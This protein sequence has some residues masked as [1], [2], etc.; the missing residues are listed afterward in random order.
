VTFNPP[1]ILNPN[2]TAH[3]LAER[4]PWKNTAGEACP[5]YGVFRI[6]S[7]NETTLHWDAKKPDGEEGLYYVNGPVPVADTKYGGAAM[8]NLPRRV[9]VDS[10]TLA[11]GDEVGPVDGEWAMSASGVGWRIMRP[12]ETGGVVATVERIGGGSS[13]VDG[14]VST[15]IGDGWYYVQLAEFT[16]DPAS[17]GEVD[18][19]VGAEC[20][21]CADID[22]GAVVDG[23]SGSCDSV[24]EVSL[25]Q[26]LA[27]WNGGVRL[28]PHHRNEE[29]E[30]GRACPDDPDTHRR[31]RAI[32]CH[33]ERTV[34]DGPAAVPDVRVLYRSR[35]R[36][37]VRSNDGL[38]LR[39]G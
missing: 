6:D 38:H 27:D 9:L 10:D 16:A 3:D 33:P 23:I 19:E 13:I 5:A 31:G 14:L 26:T 8:W 36:R 2:R 22:L 1:P 17:P 4:L 39:A 34:R 29:V 24:Q 12:P 37:A 18:P 30:D 32:L 15:C 28:R 25:T 11:V 35:H 7:F 20:D 21:A